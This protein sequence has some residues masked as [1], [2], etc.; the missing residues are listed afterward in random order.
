[1]PLL[2][3]GLTAC[4]S[5]GGSE[6]SVAKYC[7]VMEKHKDR[8]EQSMNAALND[9]NLLTG[10]VTALSALGDLSQMWKEAAAV[11]PDD[12][13]TDVEALDEWY[14]KSYDSAAENAGNPLA[15]LT[16]SLMGSMKVAGPAQRVNEYT[17]Q[18]CPG[19]GKP[20]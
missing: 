8:Y 6:R 4:D 12:I 18:N 9:E 20:F 1:M 15:G 14:S 16:S 13:K 3:A 10:S 2:L 17:E 7:A 5:G 11:A 19:V